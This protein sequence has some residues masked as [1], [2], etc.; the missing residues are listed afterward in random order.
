MQPPVRRG[1]RGTPDM[2]DS[3]AL[4]RRLS[5]LFVD[6][7]N[8]EVPAPDTDLFETG[9]LDSLRFVEL[10][11]TLEESFGVQVSV[12]ELEIDDFRSLARI[13]DFLTAKSAQPT[14]P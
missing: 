1:R 4:T 10:L 3:Q 6:R 7:L 11:A 2:P 12:E 9:I 14:P 5:R 13:A 8:T